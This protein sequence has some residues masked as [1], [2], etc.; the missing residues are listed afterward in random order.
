MTIQAECY[1]TPHK[2]TTSTT[3]TKLLD[4]SLTIRNTTTNTNITRLNESSLSSSSLTPY[5]SSSSSFN[6]SNNNNCSIYVEPDNNN[7]ENRFSLNISNINPM[8]HQ[9]FLE[10]QTPCK[11]RKETGSTT[12]IIT[13][14][15]TAPAP[16]TEKQREERFL[17]KWIN[18]KIFPNIKKQQQ[19]QQQQ[20]NKDHSVQWNHYQSIAHT[21]YLD[22]QSSPLYTVLDSEINNNPQ[23]VLQGNN[24]N[25][26][27]ITTTTLLLVI[28]PE[29]HLYSDIGLRQNII[30]LIGCYSKPWLE[31][32]LNLL[33]NSP[34]L[35]LNTLN[36]LNTKNLQVYNPNYKR[37][38]IN[39]LINNKFLYD[40]ELFDGQLNKVYSQNWD[41]EHN[42]LQIFYKTK[43]DPFILKNFIVLICVLDSLKFNSSS[44]KFFNS[45]TNSN[46][47]KR[48][49]LFEKNSKIKSSVR[50]AASVFEELCSG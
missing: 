3:K 21:I 24:N 28:K 40:K 35:T 43:I 12:T 38:K 30:N 5:K 22:F 7:I 2:N 41:K 47:W 14:T 19:Q 11:P 8:T 50:N 42:N 10:F 25:N 31:F 15:T 18:F 45:T 32:A 1:K 17:I 26:N 16:L 44:W 49:N 13:T 23:L 39:D 27:V 46:P 4:R 20:Y 37:K 9:N 36:T 48:E 34:L 29:K 6:S 33:F